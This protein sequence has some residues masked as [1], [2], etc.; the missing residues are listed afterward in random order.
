MN[1]ACSLFYDELSVKSIM[2]VIP[3]PPA[4]SA[5]YPSPHV[6]Q[7]GFFPLTHL[8]SSRQASIKLSNPTFSFLHVFEIDFRLV[9]LYTVSTVKFEVK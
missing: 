4:L 3:M 8:H 2:S 5:L 6:Q 1:N 9:G 7:G